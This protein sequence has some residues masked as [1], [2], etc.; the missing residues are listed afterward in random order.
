VNTSR[1][2]APTMYSRKIGD[3]AEN[4]LV[5]I[6][7][8]S[9]RLKHTC[10]RIKNISPRLKHTR[11]RIKHSPTRLKQTRYSI[12]G[13]YMS[14]FF[15]P[16]SK[17]YRFMSRFTDIFVLNMMW[18]L[19]SLPIVTLGAST[20]AAYTVTLQMAD[21]TE[22]HPAPEFWKAFKSNIRQGIPMSFVTILCIWVLYLD[23]QIISVTEENKII[24]MIVGIVT[25]YVFVFSLLYGYPLLARY[26]NTV[27]HCLQNSF[28]ISMRYFLRSVMLLIILAV[29]LALIFWNYT[30]IF[31][32][33]LIG[34]ALIMLT[35]SEFAIRLFR[36]IEKSQQEE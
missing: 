3:F 17:V 26:E 13:E 15:S 24:Y 20:I 36:E 5:T 1:R 8:I 9:P 31:I 10:N 18:L 6:K 4:V 27:L 29:E 16:D 2:C 23:F 25:A 35:V 28:R 12:S 14:K 19:F 7:N 30:S 33:L 11:N 21:N 22:G 34:P 32:G